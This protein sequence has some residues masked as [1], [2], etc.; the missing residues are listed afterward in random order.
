MP[1]E[2]ANCVKVKKNTKYRLKINKLYLQIE[3]FIFKI[4]SNS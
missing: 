2:D 4:K 1:K 3:N